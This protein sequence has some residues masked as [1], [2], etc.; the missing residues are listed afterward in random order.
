MTTPAWAQ[1]EPAARAVLSQYPT[2]PATVI[3]HRRCPS[4][5]DTV[6]PGQSYTFGAGRSC[7]ATVKPSDPSKRKAND[8]IL[9]LQTVCV[10]ALFGY[11]TTHGAIGPTH[12]TYAC[13]ADQRDQPDDPRSR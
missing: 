12:S 11:I 3:H 9:G 6:V 4:I 1:I 5:N 13:V 7:R 8:C 10:T 2:M